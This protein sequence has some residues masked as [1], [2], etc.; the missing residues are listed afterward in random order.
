[1]AEGSGPAGGV[2]DRDPDARR[3]G[4]HGQRGM[5]GV[6]SPRR[7]RGIRRASSSRLSLRRPRLQGDLPVRKQVMRRRQAATVGGA[8]QGDRM[9]SDG[10]SELRRGLQG[11]V[12][13]AFVRLA[14]PAVVGSGL[15]NRSETLRDVRVPDDSQFDDGR[16]E[17]LAHDPICVGA[18]LQLH[19]DQRER[20]DAESGGA[21]R[22]SDDWALSKPAGPTWVGVRR[23]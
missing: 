6:T 12:D 15:V 7:R 16:G 19:D 17:E 10:H 3:E 4:V 9:G 22:G 23:P 11:D 21:E 13:G 2:S 20:S 1:M 14:A 18:D 5:R 8:P